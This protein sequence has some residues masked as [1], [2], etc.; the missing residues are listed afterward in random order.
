MIRRDLPLELPHFKVEVLEQ[1]S[2]GRKNWTP[3][4][5][6]RDITFDPYGF[7]SYCMANWEVLIYD[8]FLVTAAVDFCDQTF[9]R[10]TSKYGWG[11]EIY[12]RIPVH[13]LDKW[14]SAPVSNSLHEALCFVTGDSWHIEFVRR[15]VAAPERT[16]PHL[17][18]PSGIESVMAYSDGMDS[19]TVAA[20]QDTNSLQRVRVGSLIGSLPKKGEPF[21][22]VPY[23]VSTPH[24]RESSQR[25][26]GFRFSIITGIAAYLLKAN[27][28]IMPESGQGALGP[29][30][31][32]VAHGYPDYRN[33]PR[34][35]KL[36]EVFM[37]RLFGHMIRYDFPRL[38]YTKGETLIA[39]RD[40]VGADEEWAT[41][42]SCWKSSRT[43]V[44]NG[45]R[46]NCGICAACMLRR[47]SVH[48]AGLDEGNENYTWANLN[49]KQLKDVP[50]SGSLY[51]GKGVPVAAQKDIVAA[52][53]HLKEL[54]KLGEKLSGRA[55][56]EAIL[57]AQVLGITKQ[58]TENKI[59][60][61]LKRHSEEWEAFIDSL[62]SESFI[63]KLVRDVL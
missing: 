40:K 42:R 56:L 39:Y 36:M 59:I 7:A 26:R 32:N 30:I 6:D 17:P 28:V 55:K 18:L 43:S 50:L 20:L 61:M 35:A 8:T 4:R 19:M 34:F 45:K 41:T 58:E 54:A 27:R 46:S 2:K 51:F 3:C 24:K 53:V 5:I 29:V 23:K 15:R 38:W 22:R 37:E 13:D 48:S 21:T 47:M 1:G 44:V 31:A 11:R 60:R 25:S 63:T 57:I 62:G 52:I 10:Q 14:S 49:A 16:E 33:H 12:L 9:A